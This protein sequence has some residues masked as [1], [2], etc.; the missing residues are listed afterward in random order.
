MH[1][2]CWLSQESAAACFSLYKLIGTC[3]HWS[4][5]AHLCSSVLPAAACMWT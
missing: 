1:S 5:R 3:F 4:S 2:M